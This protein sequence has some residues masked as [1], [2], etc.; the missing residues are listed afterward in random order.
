MKS[1]CSFSGALLPLVLVPIATA[2]PTQSTIA[3]KASNWSRLNHTIQR[4][5]NKQRPAT[6]L[7]EWQENL[8]A[9]SALVQVTEV[10]LERS[11]FGLD[12]TLETAD[13][14][15]LQID[16]TRFRAEGNVL[17]ADIANSVLSLST[18]DQFLRNNPTDDIAIVTVTQIDAETIQV[19]VTG[20]AALPT[21]E[22]TLKTGGLAYSLTPDVGAEDELVITG[23]RPSRYRPPNSSTATR[24]DTPIR[25][26]PQSIQVIPRQLLEDQNLTRVG[27]ALQTIPG[28]INQERGYEGYADYFQIRGFEPSFRGNYFSDGVTIDIWDSPETA[29]LERIEVLK[30]PASVLFG[31]GSPG[32]IINLVTKKPLFEP[33]YAISATVGSFNTYRGELD[34][35]SPLNVNKTLRYR[36]NVAYENS[37]SFRDEVKGERFFISPVI[38][39]DISPKTALTLSAI[40]SSDA[41]TPD[42]G[43]PAIGDRIA[44]VPF[45]R[46]YSEPFNYYRRS[47]WEL[48]ATLKHA[49]SDNWSITNTFR[50]QNYTPERYAIFYYEPDDSG[51]MAREGYYAGGNY[52]RYAANVDIIGKF[53]TGSIQHTLLLGAEYRQAI[54]DPEFAFGIP[55]PSINLLNPKYTNERFPKQPIF[56]RDDRDITWAGYVQN[57]IDLL[58]N[59]KLL[60]G[61]RFDSY[62]QFPTVQNLGEPRQDF[63]Q[64]DTAWSPRVGIVY[65]PTNW[66]S[67]Y[68]SYS[69]SFSPNSASS[70]D[71]SGEQFEPE[72]G[73]QFEVGLKA[74][75]NSRLSATLAFFDLRKQNVSTPDPDH[76]NF[77]VQTGEQTSKGIELG[78]AGEILPGWDVFFAYTYLD[79]FISEDNLFSV[80]NRLYNVPYNSLSLWTKYELQSGSLKGLGFGLGLY[81]IGDR[82]G[83]LD[84]TLELPGYFRADAALFYRRN[85][86]RAQINLKNLFNRD[87]VSG[88]SYGGRFVSPGAPLTVSGTFS[89]EF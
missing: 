79:A 53:K 7:Q 62:I 48:T 59:L 58:P 25:D 28:V 42:Y 77:S 11:E 82:F 24:T 17:I 13:G 49:F 75:I 55:Y 67:L 69:R 56:F 71:V 6:T 34:F 18:G 52:T 23:D 27:D 80:G 30:G 50:Y 32:G 5:S 64:H 76:P 51:E 21:T 65:Q 3:A 38:T 72:T 16:A 66:L 60:A 9:Q 20:K 41:R 1:L 35:S 61:I 44:D 26:I 81:Y 39:W 14:K 29:N 2:A 70:V 47:G 83:D 78:I 31:Q 73:R 46:F 40:F 74:D 10:T 86:W 43:I 19:M 84:N 87:Y 63:E 54:D 85:N 33:R 57:Q 22:V 15:P 12:I 4:L 88:T 68:F 8:L 37:R 45:D 89:I 36:L